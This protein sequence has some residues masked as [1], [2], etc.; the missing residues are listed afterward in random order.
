MNVSEFT[1]LRYGLF[2]HFGLYSALGRGEWVMNREQIPPAE[3]ERLARDF[4]PERFDAEA[5]CR[6]AV[7]GGMTYVV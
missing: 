5:L 4:A 2:V 6:L 7:E 3:M 1:E